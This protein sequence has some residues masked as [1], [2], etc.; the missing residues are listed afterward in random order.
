MPDDIIDPNNKDNQAPVLT[1]ALVNERISKAVNEAVTGLKTNNEALKSE[2]TEAAN[3]LKALNELVESLGGTEVLKQIGDADSLKRLAEMRSRSDADATSKLLTEGRYDEWFDQRTDALRKDQASQLSA[4]NAKLET[5]TR[6]KEES[7]AA[8]RQ[9]VLEV[10][11]STAVGAAGIIPAALADVQLRAQRL[12]SFDPELNGLV[13][14]EKDGSLV[15]GKDGKSP[16][17]IGEWLEDQ[18]EVAPH[19]WPGSKGG[20]AQGSG[21]GTGTG[22]KDMSKLSF[23]EYS[24]ARREAGFK[25]N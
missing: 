17:S 8:L 2:K 7:E 13:L 14:R 15:Y 3:Q 19:W 10:E 18:K 16:K 9:K 1:E 12:F 24:K 4:I 25:P 5:I 23:G 20:D 21:A 6:A 22:G 11:V